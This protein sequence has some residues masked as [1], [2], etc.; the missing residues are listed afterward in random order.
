MC[1]VT[2][3]SPPHKVMYGVSGDSS[4]LCAGPERINSTLTSMISIMSR[5]CELL[6]D[7]RHA[8]AVAFDVRQRTD[9]LTALC[10]DRHG[11]GL[12]Q[13]ERRAV[14]QLGVVDGLH[15]PVLQHTV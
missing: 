8:G 13:H 11:T 2:G 12:I 9:H 14:G 6:D 15:S 4:W 1:T 10:A 3:P 5:P 7:S